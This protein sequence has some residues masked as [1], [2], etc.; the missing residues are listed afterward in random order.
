MPSTAEHS[1]VSPSDISAKA[2]PHLLCSAVCQTWHTTS[3]VAKQSF[4]A[5]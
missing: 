2:K 1:T 3:A 4:I 5:V